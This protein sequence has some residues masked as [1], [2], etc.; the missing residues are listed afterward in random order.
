METDKINK[1]I[2]DTLVRIEHL[3]KNL[4]NNLV[5]VGFLKKDLYKIKTII[6][7]KNGK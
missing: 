5:K 3:K 4:D 1:I 6:G 7:G 2:E